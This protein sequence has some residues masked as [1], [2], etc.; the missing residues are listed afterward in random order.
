MRGTKLRL[1]SQSVWV[2]FKYEKMASF[3]FYCGRMDHQE[4]SCSVRTGDAR[5]RKLQL[6]QYGLWLR[7]EA[8]RA[9]PKSPSS[10]QFQKAATSSGVPFDLASNSQQ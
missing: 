6:G 7:A 10:S 4:K 9:V 8:N 5:V 3:C 1:D 2:E